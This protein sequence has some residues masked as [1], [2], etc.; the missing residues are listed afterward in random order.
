MK[1]YSETRDGFFENNNLGVIINGESFFSRI[2]NK[3][4]R[5]KTRVRSE[6]SNFRKT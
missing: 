1:K 6:F 3:A 4:K 2:I 5:E